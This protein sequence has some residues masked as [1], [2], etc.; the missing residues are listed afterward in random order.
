MQ[1]GGIKLQSFLIF[2]CALL[3][4]IIA[5]LRYEFLSKIILKYTFI[6]YGKQKK[7]MSC[8]LLYYNNTMFFYIC[9]CIYICIYMFDADEDL[10]CHQNSLLL[11][12]LSDTKKAKEI[13]NTML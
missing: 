11:Y 9:I 13:L 5:L 12:F 1:F 7:S 2:C 10:M 3:V 8:M 6:Y 4:I